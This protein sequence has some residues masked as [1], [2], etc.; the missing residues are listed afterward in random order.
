[1]MRTNA[2]GEAVERDT[3]MCGDPKTWFP[4]RMTYSRELKVKAELDRLGIACYVS[5][6]NKINCRD[7]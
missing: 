1:M 7:R 2:V 3:K 5:I 4:M 6:T